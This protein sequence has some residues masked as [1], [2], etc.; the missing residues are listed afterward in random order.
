M[1]QISLNLFFSVFLTTSVFAQYLEINKMDEFFLPKGYDCTILQAKDDT[2]VITCP[3]TYAF[4]Y[5]LE[6][7]DSSNIRE[8]KYSLGRG[9][10]EFNRAPFGVGILRDR[11]V[12]SDPDLQRLIIYNFEEDEFSTKI[13]SERKSF[14]GVFTMDSKNRVLITGYDQSLRGYI[15]NMEEDKVE[16]QILYPEEISSAFEGDGEIAFKKDKMMFG[17]LYHGYVTIW[18]TVNGDNLGRWQILK[19]E[20]VTPRTANY[21]GMMGSIPPRTEYRL[22]DVDFSPFNDDHLLVL[23]ESQEEKKYKNNYLYLYDMDRSEIISK[24]KLEGITDMFEVE[25]EYLYVHYE[26]LDKLVKY[27]LLAR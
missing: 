7:N 12:F 1:K 10:G 5:T 15:Y 13:L 16:L 25:G 27:Q 6:K 23:I 9:P 17:S 2:A 3:N 18:N 24:I 20:K 22:S 4:F 26:E 14:S 21:N 19:A 11:I 8:V